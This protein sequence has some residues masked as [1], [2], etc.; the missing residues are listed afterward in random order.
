MGASGARAPGADD[1][2]LLGAHAGGDEAAILEQG[3]PGGEYRAERVRAPGHDVDGEPVGGKAA[4]RLIDPVER[5]VHQQQAAAGSEQRGR[6]VADTVED[7]PAV[8]PPVPRACCP[9]LGQPVGG[10]RD[11]GRVGD[12]DVEALAGDRAAE[13][14]AADSHS[15]PPQVGVE[16]G[17][18]QRSPG[19]VD[20]GDAAA[21]DAGGYGRYR[22]GAGPELE[23]PGTRGGAVGQLPTHDVG[24]QPGVALHGVHT[25]EAHNGQV[26][27]GPGGPTR[28][29]G[30]GL[31]PPPHSTT[32][33]AG[34]TRGGARG[35]GHRTSSSVRW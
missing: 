34:R 11:V 13:V 16:P 9:V 31:G 19:E 2:E 4:H 3:S 20:G 8:A 14:P 1:D 27:P 30:P 17:A 21:G 7:H 24:E 25:G 35:N 29:F 22:T 15:A 10:R 32:L 18:G 6:L 26:S 23:H 28:E 12:D 33:S 5:R